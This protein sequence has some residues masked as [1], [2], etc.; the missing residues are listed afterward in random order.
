MVS[1]GFS[2]SDS[3]IDVGRGANNIFLAVKWIWI[4]TTIH[5]P[6]NN[7]PS[8][9][10][11]RGLPPQG[12]GQGLGDGQVPRGLQDPR[13][14]HPI[15]SESR[16]AMDSGFGRKGGNGWKGK[17]GSQKREAGGREGGRKEGR[18]EGRKKGSR[19]ELDPFLGC[20]L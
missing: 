17:E 9:A 15:R 4:S 13:L 18:K 8:G 19:L 14:E 16:W 7:R 12:V 11:E 1:Y 6:H 5:Y 10:E 2:P 3:M 20:L